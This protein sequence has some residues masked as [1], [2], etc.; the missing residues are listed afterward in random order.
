[1]TAD[2]LEAANVLRALAAA[3]D[4]AVV[5]GEDAATLAESLGAARKACAA[6]QA[7][8]ALRAADCGA[9]RL[10]GFAGAHEW[11][12][13]L[14]GS[15]AGEARAALE[16]VGAVER[17]PET[18]AAL[19]AGDLSLAQAGVIAGAEEACPGS[20]AALVDL[21]GRSDLG[22]LKDEARRRRLAA[23]DPEELSARQ[24]RHRSLRHWRD[25]EGMVRLSVALAPAAGVAV[26][27]RIEAETQRLRRRAGAAEQRE[28][29]EAVAADALVAL[30]SG[31]SS[32]PPGRT[33]VVVVC[34]L[35]AWRRGHTHGGETCHI[36]GGGPVGVGVAMELAEDAFFKAV[37]HDGVAIGT[38]THLGRHMPAHLRTALDLG[39]LPELDGV[40]CVEEGCGR[41]YGLEWD[42]VD[43]VANGGATSF[44]NLR[45]RCQPHH[46]EKTER[47]RRAGLLGPGLAAVGPP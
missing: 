32:G 47:D 46:A 28:S 40:T 15:S 45:P 31:T 14:S 17:C 1:M 44:D 34:D 19:V 38:V 27:N 42:H 33:E 24:H 37:V 18:K 20:E 43:P 10:R 36:M 23:V 16:A 5:S 3:F 30:A 6:A 7:R 39:P 25:A 11:L 29:F 21:A 12:G 41:R 22:T 9:H 26:V 13:R 35:A 4:P 8:A 2:L